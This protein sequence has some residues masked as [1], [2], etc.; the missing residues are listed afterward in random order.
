MK[1]TVSYKPT[2]SELVKASSLYI[3]QK[4]FFRVAILAVNAF[5]IL[6]LLLLLI[7]FYFASLLP[8]EWLA[9]FGAF[10]WLFGR[11]PLNEWLLRLKLK[12]IHVLDSPLKIEISLNGLIWSAKGLIPGH[13]AWHDIKYVVEAQ[14]GYLVPDS[15]THFLWIPF[16]GFTSQH[17]LEM[18]KKH[19]EEKHIKI[20]L[21]KKWRC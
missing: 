12:N 16:H 8:N 11:R 14:N 4:P 15:A 17:D 10:A 6:V 20:R 5:S 19:L 3:E 9:M 21:Y 13:L 18:L 2:L 1:I 7:K